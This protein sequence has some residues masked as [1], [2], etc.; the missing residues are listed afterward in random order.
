M[1]LRSLANDSPI[2]IVTGGAGFLGSHLCHRLL[3]NGYNVLCI[4]NFYTGNLDN[5]QEFTNNSRFQLMEADV[6][7]PG[8]LNQIKASG[9]V[10]AY[11]FNLACPASPP[12]YQK[13]PRYTLRTAIYG[14]D[15]FLALAQET[16]A[17]FFQASTS[18]VYGDPAIHPQPENY[19][20]NVNPDGERS[21]YDEGKRVGETFCVA[22]EKE[23]V[24]VRIARF[25]NTYGPNMDPKD[26]RVVSNMICQALKGDNITIY[27][28]GTQTR[29]FCYVDDL[30]EGITRLVFD[31]NYHGP[32]NLGNPGEFTMRELAD[33]IKALTESKSDIVFLSLPGDDPKKRQ[34]DTTLAKELL[35]GWTAQVPLEAGLRKTIPYFAHK[36]RV[37]NPI[38]PGNAVILA[39]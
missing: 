3:K 21:C 11:I 9:I 28:D 7:D 6:V 29:S 30:I 5:I 38:K 13:D 32:V 26:G 20:G 24:D 2:C 36:L 35:K 15:N 33:L 27:G 19:W 18:E 23:G 25:F 16:G 10:P 37:P 14:T 34:P 17:T 31:S 1:P 39:A 22:Y 8:T 12:A 4:D